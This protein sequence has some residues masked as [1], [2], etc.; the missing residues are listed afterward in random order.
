MKPQ[1]AVRPETS[2]RASSPAAFDV[3]RTTANRKAFTPILH[4]QSDDERNVVTRSR[5]P[6]EDP[7]RRLK[8][9]VYSSHTGWPSKYIHITPFQK[10]V[11]KKLSEYKALQVG[12]SIE[13]NLR[14]CGPPIPLSVCTFGTKHRRNQSR[15]YSLGAERVS[16]VRNRVCAGL[17]SCLDTPDLAFVWH[18]CSEVALNIPYPCDK[19][20]PCRVCYDPHIYCLWTK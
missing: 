14:N 8:H 19:L 3:P 2:L 6:G 13:M 17:W 11:G 15:N 10:V 1:H 5:L 16:P 20:T 7:T 4:I 12:N 9:C 18:L